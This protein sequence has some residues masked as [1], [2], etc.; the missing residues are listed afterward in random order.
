MGKGGGSGYGAG[1]GSGMY[2]GKFER[3]IVPA[4]PVPIAILCCILNFIIPGLGSAISGLTVFCCSRNE[5]LD[6]SAR[7]LSCVTSCGIGFLQLVTTVLFFIGWIWSCFWGLTFIV[8]S[9]EYYHNN[10]VDDYDRGTAHVENVPATHVVYEAGSSEPS[11]IIV[12]PSHVPYMAVPAGNTKGTRQVNVTTQPQPAPYG[13]SQPG[14]NTAG[15]KPTGHVPFRVIAGPSTNQ[16]QGD[17]PTVS[18]GVVNPPSYAES[19]GN[20]AGLFPSAPP[21]A[22]SEKPPAEAMYHV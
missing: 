3:V 15:G 5:D 20:N 4:M 21:P 7:I 9:L 16:T 14:S 1:W 10:S 13:A 19:T 17:I 2:K 11:A 8:M 22:Y 6:K 18:A 12:Q